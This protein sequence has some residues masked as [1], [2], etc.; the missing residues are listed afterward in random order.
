MLLSLLLTVNLIKK[1]TKLDKREWLFLLSG[2]ID[3]TTNSTPN[4]SDWISEKSWNEII[5][6]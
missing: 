3:T 2:G 1:E 6:Y 4:S 5:K